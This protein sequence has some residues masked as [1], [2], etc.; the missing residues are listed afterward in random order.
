MVVADR[1]RADMENCGADGKRRWRISSPVLG[2]VLAAISLVCLS[3][4]AFL[5]WWP[6]RGDLEGM[7]VRIDRKLEMTGSRVAE[8]LGAFQEEQ[9]SLRRAVD[10]LGRRSL[11]GSPKG[12]I[13]PS[14]SQGERVVGAES[15]VA[16]EESLPPLPD[17]VKP[18]AVLAKELPDLLGDRSL[19]P[20]AR[21]LGLVETARAQGE[22]VK[23]RCALKVLDSETEVDVAVG[24]EALR[25][26]GAYVEYKTG[27]R[28]EKAPGVITSGESIPG[29]GVR[30]FYLYPEKFPEIYE[31]RV[32]KE[33]I[34][35]ESARRLLAIIRGVG[36]GKEAGRVVGE[37]G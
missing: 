19:N 35:E 8:A 13:E 33:A 15:P 12:E 2:W 28:Y 32:R 6:G 9:R 21:Q 1:G 26:E 20:A 30:M 34:A 5:R 23:A 37:G 10:D 29:D 31:R 14:E 27:E 36:E 22:L 4:V 25:R 18:P 16:P 24:M 7:A 3:G 11:G 17:G